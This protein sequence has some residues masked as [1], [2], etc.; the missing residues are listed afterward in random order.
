MHAVLGSDASDPTFC[1]EDPS[2]ESLALLTATVDEE[3]GRIF[4][5]LPEEIEALDPIRGRGEE[6][7][8]SLARSRTRARSAS[9]SARTA[10]C[11]SARRC[12]RPSATTGR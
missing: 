1:S 2:A 12:G 10:T 8:E 4:V 9:R 6:V 7:R 11:T 3:I 5:E